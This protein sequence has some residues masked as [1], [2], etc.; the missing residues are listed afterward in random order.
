[1]VTGCSVCARDA[2]LR[3]EPMMLTPLPDYPWQVVGS[4]LFTLGTSIVIDYFP[5]FKML[6]S[7]SSAST[8]ATLK[9]MF[10]RYRTPN[11]AR[12]NFRDL[13]HTT[14][15]GQPKISTEQWPGQEDCPNSQEAAPKVRGPFSVLER[16]D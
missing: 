8:I 13:W 5:G 12:R 14:S 15:D 3:K 10:A 4:D 7:A 1:M 6:I 11:T 2:A 16:R 9:A